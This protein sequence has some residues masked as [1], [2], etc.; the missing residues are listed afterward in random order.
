MDSTV[1]SSSLSDLDFASQIIE[2]ADKSQD[3]FGAIT[4]GEVVGTEVFVF[5][6]VS[7]HVPDGGEHG[8]GHGEDGFLGA[9]SQELSLQV[10]NYA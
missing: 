7:Q 6:V 10:A 4:T 5:D 8:G 1:D 3:R 9:E 2:A